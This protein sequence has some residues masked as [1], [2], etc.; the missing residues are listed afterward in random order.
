MFSVE[1]KTKLVSRL[2]VM[3][4]NIETG[5]ALIEEAEKQLKEMK[6]NQKDMIK[7]RD[8]YALALKAYEDLG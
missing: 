5:E 2:V 6:D 7:L 4:K 1:E 8:L 3:N